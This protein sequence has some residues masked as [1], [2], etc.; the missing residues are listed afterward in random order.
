V[1]ASG[2]VD[3]TSPVN[4]QTA[5]AICKTKVES[6]VGELSDDTFSPTFLRNATAYGASPR[7]RFDIVLNNL[8]GLAHTTKE[9]A[10]T[11]DGTPWRPLVHA[12]DICRAIR[13][14]LTAPTDA[15]HNEIFNVGHSDHNYRIRTVA[16]I[17]GEA[18]PGCTVSFGEPAPDNRSYRV[19][20]EKIRE[21]LPGFRCEWDAR[22][23][24]EQL[25]A[26]F[27]SIRMDEPTFCAPPFT[28]LRELQW[29]LST[30]QIDRR[31]FWSGGAQ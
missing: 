4:P 31:F 16:E 14:T 26:V 25:R 17:V 12:L 18:F 24:A 13:L 9:I 20:F 7:M 19:R 15:I 5:Y 6:D 1:A 23:G 10:L 30:G 21:H 2:F 22:R 29:L 8:A 3:E 28:R 27:D 11:S